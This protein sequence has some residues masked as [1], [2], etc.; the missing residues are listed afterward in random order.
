MVPANR[1]NCI[2]DDL[3]LFVLFVAFC[4]NFNSIN[5][6]LATGRFNRRGTQSAELISVRGGIVD[7]SEVDGLRQFSVAVSSRSAARVRAETPATA[8]THVQDV[9]HGR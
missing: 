4:E 9:N 7:V 8:V 5:H 6:E 3:E 2:A 1:Q